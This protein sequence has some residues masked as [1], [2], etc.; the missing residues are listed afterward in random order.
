MYTKYTK[1]D[2]NRNQLIFIVQENFIMN[3]KLILATGSILTEELSSIPRYIVPI[4]QK[5]GY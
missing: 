1:I 4:Q 2:F 5:P 3:Y